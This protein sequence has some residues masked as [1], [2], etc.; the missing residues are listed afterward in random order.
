MGTFIFI[1]V[2]IIIIITIG[3]T[4]CIYQYLLILDGCIPI[5]STYIPYPTTYKSS[6]NPWA[7]QIVKT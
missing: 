5:H 3:L 6:I 1:I 7:Q 2:I 4:A